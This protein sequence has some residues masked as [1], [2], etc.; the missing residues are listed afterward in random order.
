MVISCL[1][2]EIPPN[3]KRENLVPWCIVPFDAAKRGPAERSTML[4]ELGLRRCAY[5]WRSKHVAEFEEE[6]LQYEKHG[7]EYFAFWGQHD[8]AF[9]L[10]GKY[11]LHPQIWNTLP[12][13]G[14]ATQAE[15]VASATRALLA[16]AKHTAEMGC[17]LGLYNHGGWGGEPANLI[18]VC[19]AL[20]A[21]GHRHVGIVY[22][23]H[24]GHARI[25]SWAEDLKEMLPFLHCVNL[26]GMNSGAKP[27][28]LALGQGEHELS[29]L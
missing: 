13:P 2:E 26:N 21:A 4:A 6:I 8:Q 7:I 11:D 28:I 10:F 19:R 5:D 18:A 12:S 23:W 24:H 22:N 27:K 14:K 25:G 20:R 17:K 1:A 16:L 15:N 9:R 3:L 29:M